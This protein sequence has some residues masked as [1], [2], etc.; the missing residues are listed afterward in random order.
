MEF[1]K[2][3]QELRK[4]KGL[5]Q[6]ELA[7]ALFVS[8]TAVSKWE[9]GRGYPNIDSLRAIASFFSV[10]VDQLLSCEQALSIADARSKQ[11]ESRVRDLVF[12][13]LDLGTIL[14]FFL[15]IFAQRINGTIID[16][17][18]LSLSEISLYLKIGYI[19]TVSIIVLI[20]ILTL[21]LQSFCIPLWTQNKNKISLAITAIGSLLFTLSLQPYAAAL[22]F[23]FLAIKVLISVNWK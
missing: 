15:P 22:L 3:L 16:V 12:G 13:F 7:S 19:V 5:T 4:Q 6:E 21:A 9:S 1:N 23:I 20:G 2:K 10:T 14:L 17:G 18:M 11:N 8:R